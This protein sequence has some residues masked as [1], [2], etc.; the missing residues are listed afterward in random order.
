M[1][2]LVAEA[3]RLADDGVTE[4]ILV[5]QETT[6]YGTEFYVVKVGKDNVDYVDFYTIYR[7]Y[8]IEIVMTHMGSAGLESEGKAEI[9]PVTDEE[10]RLAVQF[11]SELDFLSESVDSPAAY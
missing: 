3:Q 9:V 6:I 10:I 4:L 8:E 2:K 5:A 1:D 7:G 11:L